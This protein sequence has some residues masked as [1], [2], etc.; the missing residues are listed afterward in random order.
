MLTSGLIQKRCFVCN[1]FIVKVLP[2]VFVFIDGLNGCD[3]QTGDSLSRGWM[4][5]D[6]ERCGD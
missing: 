1:G 5:R 3:T 6:G 2:E 4:P